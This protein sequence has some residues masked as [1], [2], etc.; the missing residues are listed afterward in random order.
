[1]TS[2]LQFQRIFLQKHK[3]LDLFSH[4]PVL[5]LTIHH[6]IVSYARPILLPA[7]KHEVLVPQKEPLQLAPLSAWYLLYFKNTENKQSR[8]NQNF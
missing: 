5:G 7:V 4:F 1:M 3:R 8:A 6:V 2:F